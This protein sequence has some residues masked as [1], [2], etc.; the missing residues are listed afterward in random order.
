MQAK[1]NGLVAFKPFAKA[2]RSSTLS[3]AITDFI[4]QQRINCIAHYQRQIKWIS[5]G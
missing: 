2:A 4:G 3:P 1:V 5:I